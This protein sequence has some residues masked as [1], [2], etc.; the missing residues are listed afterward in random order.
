MISNYLESLQPRLKQS[1]LNIYYNLTL[2]HDII[3]TE[4]SHAATSKSSSPFPSINESVCCNFIVRLSETP[5]ITID[6]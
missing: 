6:H 2:G 1:F 4:D 3:P 5:M